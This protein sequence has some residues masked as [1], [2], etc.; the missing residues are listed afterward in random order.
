MI[1]LLVLLLPFSQAINFQYDTNG[2]TIQDDSFHY[3]YD[4][5]NQ[6]VKAFNLSGTLIEQY[7]YDENGKRLTKYEPLI[8]QTTYYINENYILITNSSGSFDSVYYYANDQLVA[9]EDYRNNTQYYH[10]DHLGST[11]LITNQT[12]DILEED[13]YLPFGEPE[14]ASS[15]LLM[16]TGKEQDKGTGLLYYGARYYKPPWF[17]QPDSVIADVYNPQDLNRYSYVRNNPYKYVDPT[18]EFP[19]D[20]VDVGL[21]VLDIKTARENPSLENVGWAALSAASLLPILPNVAGYVRYGDK[22]LDFTKGLNR[23][24]NVGGELLSPTARNFRENVGRLS[25]SALSKSEEAH[26]VFPQSKEFTARFEKA[27]INIH[28]P[29]FGA[30]VDKTAHKQF[31]YDYNKD[32][33]EFFKDYPNP[34]QKQILTQGEK[35]S[36]KYGFTINYN[37]QTSIKP[38]TTKPFK[39]K[40][41]RQN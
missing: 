1:I 26:H 15:S 19:W 28:D 41:R 32:W 13:S 4:A 27:G 39:S 21:F 40:T 16:Y 12:G 25:G 5:F 23:V 34:T 10:P 18:G 8:N 2:N 9:V 14:Q 11:T 3:E 29:Q 38:T 31:S 37:T 30:R 35:L 24:E 33:R 17:I 6:L 20:V 36:K 22:A 7:T